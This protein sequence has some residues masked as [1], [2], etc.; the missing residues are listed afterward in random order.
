MPKE[1]LFVTTNKHKVKEVQ[2]VLGK[3]WKLVQVPLP[4]LEGDYASI[5]AIAMSKAVQAFR[6]LKKPLIVED[7]G[8]YFTALNHF[9]GTKPKRRFQEL[10]YKGLLEKVAGKKKGM[11]FQSTV[12][13]MNAKKHKLF[14]GKCTGTITDKP[15]GLKKDVLPYE[16]IFIPKGYDKAES[17]LSRNI[18]NKISHRGKVA[19][20]LKQFLSNNPKVLLN[21]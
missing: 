6:E 2:A 19:L 10:G 3:R 11:Y 13:F 20:K 1:L 5:E 17:L 8:I 15:F 4:L 18:K 16:R 9:P 12:C 14:S 21:L 7:T